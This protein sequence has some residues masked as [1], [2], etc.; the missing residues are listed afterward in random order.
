MCDY[1]AIFAVVNR[2]LLESDIEKQLRRRKTSRWPLTKE[3]IRG[4]EC[5]EKMMEVIKALKVVSITE[6]KHSEGVDLPDEE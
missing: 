3:F 4:T 6:M 5:M 2:A 1:A